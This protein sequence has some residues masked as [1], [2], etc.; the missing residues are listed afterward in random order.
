MRQ[1]RRVIRTWWRWFISAI[2]P[3]WCA[4]TASLI[5]D[6]LGSVRR[7]PSRRLTG[8]GRSAAAARLCAPRP[9]RLFAREAGRRTVSGLT[10]ANWAA[11]P[12]GCSGMGTLA[13]RS[14]GR[15]AAC[16]RTDRRH[17][18]MNHHRQMRTFEDG[19]LFAGA[20]AYALGDLRGDVVEVRQ[21]AGHDRKGSTLLLRGGAP[22]T[23]PWAHQPDRRC[24]A[25]SRL[26]SSF[27]CQTVRWAAHF[28][29]WAASSGAD[30][31]RSASCRSP[32]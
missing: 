29:Q 17:E 24:H 2:G 18:R 7:K 25:P 21:Q 9:D 28:C 13:S 5:R 31:T 27:R 30:N 6:S 4:T 3:W 12:C 32:T 11:R 1:P 22:P 20:G 15:S 19:A 8:V 14:A 16:Q 10:A 23:C 26:R